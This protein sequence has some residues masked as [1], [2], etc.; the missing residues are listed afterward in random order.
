MLDVYTRRLQSGHAT[1]WGKNGL[2]GHV[3]ECHPN[4]TRVI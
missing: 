3:R 2:V 4:G 1:F